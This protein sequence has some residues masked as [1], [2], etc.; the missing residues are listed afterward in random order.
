MKLG[1]VLAGGGIRGAA[2]IGAIKALEEDGIKVDVVA[3]TSA[4]S[5]VAALYG[6]GYTA[7]EMYEILKKYAKTVMGIT[8]RYLFENLRENN[9]IKVKGIVSG[10]NI[11]KVFQEIAKVKKIE[12]IDDIKMPIAIIASD[13]LQSRKVVFT[14][15]KNLTEDSYPEDINIGTAVRA[16]CSVPG[17]YAPVEIENYQLV[18]GGIFNNLPV[19]EAKDIGA[20]K[21]LAIKFNIKNKRKYNTLYNI[22]MQ[23][24]DLMT[25]NLIQDSI[26]QSDVLINLDLKDTKSF[27]LSKIEMCYEQGYKQTKERISEIKQLM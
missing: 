3:G 13:L 24:I 6:M 18:D 27:N 25:E 7:D 12:T 8:P 16:S 23:S 19:K 17:V 9:G 5:M 21:I 22:A 26:E 11:E 10:V 15:R 4:G 14:N 1:L 20:D 2:H